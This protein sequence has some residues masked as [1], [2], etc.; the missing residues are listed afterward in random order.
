MIHF[1]PVYY[2]E[3]GARRVMG[4]SLALCTQ[5]VPAPGQSVT[6][7]T[8]KPWIDCPECLLRLAGLSQADPVAVPGAGAEK[9]NGGPEGPGDPG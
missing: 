4:K 3:T 5:P 9:V 8:N 6:L 1:G 7:S 2:D